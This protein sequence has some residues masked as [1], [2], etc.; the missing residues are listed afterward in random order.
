[1]IAQGILDIEP[2]VIIGHEVCGT[3]EVVGE[4]VEGLAVGQLVALDPPVP[5]R[6]CRVCRAG[7]R[8]MCPDTR[9]IGAHIPGG[10]AEYITIDYR[11]AYAVPDGVP[12]G[13]ASLAEPFAAALEAISQ[14]GG[15]RGKT[16]CVFGDGPFG[17][18]LSTLAARQQAAQVMLFGH[19]SARMA[20]VDDRGVLVFDEREVDVGA[21]IRAR[22][23]GYG[24]QAIIDTTGDPR[25]L[26]GAARWLMPRGVLV[27]FT[28]PG[29]PC[30]IDLDEMHFRELAVKGSC[31]SLDMFPTALEAIREDAAWAEGLISCTLPIEQV[32]HGF[33]LI[34]SSKDRIVKVA[35]VFA[36]NGE[37]PG[38][39]S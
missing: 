4:G 2:P 6:T 8:H 33:E 1:M 28:P 20:L 29:T 18:I 3:V 30:G 23:E 7:L 27:L 34:R 17:L 12:P 19:H 11:N 22:T 13:A 25:I 14:A 38:A 15:V 32:Q 39:C 37:M 26:R 31:R 36:P 16:V 10:L 35:V 24:A 21:C 9:H 5:C